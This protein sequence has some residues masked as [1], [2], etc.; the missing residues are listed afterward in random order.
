MREICEATQPRKVRFG[1]IDAEAF[2]QSDREVQL[3]H[4]VELELLA[5]WQVGID[6]QGLRL[7]RNS[8]QYLDDL[9]EQSGVFAGAGH[10]RSGCCSS[11]PIR[12][13]NCAPRRPSL[14]R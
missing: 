11:A 13:R 14:T 6:W 5:Q 12:A 8:C 4:G 10:S 1:D 3:I 9:R 7:R 2:M